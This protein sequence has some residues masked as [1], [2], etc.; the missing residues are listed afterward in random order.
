M[1]FPFLS[2]YLTRHLQFTEIQA[3]W[4]LSCYG[5]GAMAGTL[6]GGWF[7]DKYG[8]FKI[9]S[10]S[11]IL[12]GIGWLIIAQI[13]QFFTLIIFV[14]FQTFVSESFRPANSAAIATI[15]RPDNLTRSYSLNRM[16][17][18]MG[19]TLGPMIAGVLATISY[20]FLFMVDGFTSI[21][22][23]I[24][25][26]I[27]FRKEFFE[28]NI[29]VTDKYTAE[30]RYKSDPLKDKIFLAFTI[31]TVIF[32][33]LFFQL[34]FTLPLYYKEVY[35]MNDKNVGFLLAVNGAIV[36]LSEMVLVHYLSRYK[37]Y[38]LIIIGVLL[39]GGSFLLL[40][41][42]HGFYWLILGMVM[43]SYGEI[44]TMPFMMSFTSN[45]ANDSSRGR[46]MAFYSLTYSIGLILA[47]FIG[48]R[49]IKHFGYYSLWW[50]VFLASIIIG[51]GYYFILRK[52]KADPVDE[53]VVSPA[54]GE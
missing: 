14:F 34:L 24:L 11:L 4:I 52:Y 32:A 16:A 44:L 29:P 6:F 48:L 39:I 36:F 3:S 30:N 27:I 54:L 38:K 41:F 40:N 20:Y 45:K 25:F 17:I 37:I 2:I 47:P 49:I 43:I 12:A 8:K 53:V 42:F 7:S 33:T 50:L 28:R 23:G 31:C 13:T 35:Q 46:Y 51:V 10:M 9:Q 5:L 18:N 1:V 26:F 15:A 22:S 19:F 21:F